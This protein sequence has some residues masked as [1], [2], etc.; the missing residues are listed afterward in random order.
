MM[1]EGM[2]EERDINDL[3]CYNGETFSNKNEA[4]WCRGAVVS[5]TNT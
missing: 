5:R 3:S 2:T 4:G 1:L